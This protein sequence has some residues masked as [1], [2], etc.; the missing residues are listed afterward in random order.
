M[1]KKFAQ[2]GSDLA[3]NILEKL[4]TKLTEKADEKLFNWLDNIL[5]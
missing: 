3:M 1:A 2:K 5:G 4:G